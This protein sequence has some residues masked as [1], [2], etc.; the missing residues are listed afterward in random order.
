MSKCTSLEDFQLTINALERYAEEYRHNLYLPHF[1]RARETVISCLLNN[2]NYKCEILDI[3]CGTALDAI[4]LARHGHQITGIDISSTMIS[5][6][7]EEI[8]RAGVSALV[9]VEVADMG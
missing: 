3:N 6:A 5:I 7:K 4:L 1:L 8:A 9:K 2:L